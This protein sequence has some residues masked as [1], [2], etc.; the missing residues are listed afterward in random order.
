MRKEADFNVMDNIKV[1]IAEN[2]KLVGI[3]KSN[4]EVIKSDVLATEFIYGDTKGFT[5]QWDI[6]GENCTLGVE[7]I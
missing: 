3:I 6:N 1:S 7:K 2:D 5:K 4:V